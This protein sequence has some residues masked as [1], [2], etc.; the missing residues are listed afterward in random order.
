M[1]FASTGRKCSGTQSYPIAL[2]EG[3]IE[4]KSKASRTQA[5]MKRN[6]LSL[7][8]NNFSLNTQLSP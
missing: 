7:K 5:V 2:E 3:F 4:G 6:N 8:D 1:I